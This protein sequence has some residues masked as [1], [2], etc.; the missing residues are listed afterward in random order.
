MQQGHLLAGQG[1]LQLGMVCALMASAS[2]LQF[3][4]RYSLPVS[5]TCV[6]SPTA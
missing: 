3:A 5:T 4:N 1:L 2:W 6:R